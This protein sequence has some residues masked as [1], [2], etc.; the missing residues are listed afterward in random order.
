MHSTHNAAVAAVKPTTFNGTFSFVANAM[1]DIKAMLKARATRL[2]LESL[3]DQ[4]LDDIGLTRSDIK[5]I[6]RRHVR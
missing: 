6:A 4:E 2:E 3:S 5:D 1:L